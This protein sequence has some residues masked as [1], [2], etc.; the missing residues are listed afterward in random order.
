VDQDKASFFC[1]SIIKSFKSLYVLTLDPQVGSFGLIFLQ[2]NFNL[3]TNLSFRGRLYKNAM[4]SRVGGGM[5][6]SSSGQ[7]VLGSVR[8]NNKSSNV[9]AHSDLSENLWVIPNILAIN[10]RI[11][12][13]SNWEVKV[14]FWLGAGSL[15]SNP[16]SIHGEM[17]IVGTR[18]PRRS[19]LN[20]RSFFLPSG[21]GTPS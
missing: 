21:L 9:A 6:G 15:I 4:L 18:S 16:F 13:C 8:V 5:K 17:R 3:F 19:K 1:S 12:E 11:E 7:S 2:M 14:G 20:P 10:E